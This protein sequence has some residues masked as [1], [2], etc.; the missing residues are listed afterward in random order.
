MTRRWLLLAVCAVAGVSLSATDASAY[1]PPPAVSY[2][3]VTGGGDY[4]FVVIG[5]LGW[6]YYDDRAN[7]ES[8]PIRAAYPRSGMYRNDGSAEPLWVFGDA[9]T[10]VYRRDLTVYADGVH[11]AISSDMVREPDHPGIRFYARGE[12]VRSYTV[13]DLVARPDRLYRGETSH[14]GYR[15]LNR[16]DADDTRAELTIQTA[17][18]GR[19]VFDVRTGAILSE[20]RPM[21]WWA[22]VVRVLVVGAVVAAAALVIRFRRAIPNWWRPG[23]D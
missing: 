21:E 5:P 14:R 16:V 6:P 10:Y 22:V 15:W 18:G 2:K 7:P 23:R 1:I 9:D 3:V 19:F 8:I 20:S 17:D 4:V 13:R 11:L 12:L